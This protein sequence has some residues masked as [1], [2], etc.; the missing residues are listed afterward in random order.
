MFKRRSVL[1][2]WCLSYGILLA[3]MAAMGMVLH[4]D[5]RQQLVDE[6][7][8]ITQTLQQQTTD[9]MADYFD[10]LEACSYEVN[11]DY[12]VNDFLS[13]TTFSGSGDSKYYN[14]IPI[15]ESLSVYDL[16]ANGTVARYIYMENIQRALSAFTIYRQHD[17]FQTLKL[18]SA[19]SEEDFYA[20]LRRSHY[21]ELFVFDSEDTVQVLMLTSIPSVG[22]RPKGTLVQVLDADTISGAMQANSAV[23]DSTTVLMD[24]SGRI[25]SATGNREAVSLLEGADISAARDSEI[26]LD[27]RLYWIQ[28]GA[29]SQTGWDLVT[30]VPMTSIQAKSSQAINSV[31]PVMVAIILVSAALCLCF[32]YIQYKPLD[33]LRKKIGVHAAGEGKNEYEQLWAGFSDIATSK[34][35]IQSL[36]ED[37]AQQLRQEFAQSCIEGYAIYDEAHLRQILAQL[38][39]TFLGDWFGV[40]LFDFTDHT[41]SYEDA[42]AMVQPQESSEAQSARVYLFDGQFGWIALLNAADEQTVRARMEQLSARLCAAAGESGA[43]LAQA[44]SRPLQGLKNIHLAY[45]EVAESWRYQEDRLAGKAPTSQTAQEGPQTPYLSREQ[46]ELLVRYVTAGNGQA[47]GALVELVIRHNWDERALPIDICRCVAYDLLCNILRA[48]GEMNGLLD[49]RRDLVRADLHGLRHASSKEELAEDLR[50]A[51]ARYCELCSAWHSAGTVRKKQSIDHIIECV[52]KHYRDLGFNVSKA[53][54]YLGMSTPY[55]SNLF[56][57]QTGIN[58]LNYINGLRVKYAKQLILERHITVA[59]AAQQAGFENINTFIRIFK[60][61]EGTTPGNIKV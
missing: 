14:L 12:L 54:E 56:K 36:W 16:Q 32:L 11:N 44:S 59:E 58:L 53:A 3:L 19:M 22:D 20:L 24:E 49:G 40:V 39:V 42:R 2:T 31:F 45:L 9:A 27:G 33:Q 60:K 46:E 52:D 30:V 61:Y 43:A 21:N 18:S 10:T 47:A 35:Q 48:A 8:S 4:R 50:Q 25:I 55:L 6:Y 13:T 29:L 5:V 17:F 15:Q 34:D 1:L 23:E 41:L 37:Q 28:Q 51:T 7:K 57:Q 26:V 38:D